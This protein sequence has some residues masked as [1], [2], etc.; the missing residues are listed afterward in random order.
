MQ[1]EL[2]YSRDNFCRTRDRE[3]AVALGRLPAGAGLISLWR[4]TIRQIEP[5]TTA[6]RS[7]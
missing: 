5:V 1:R 6:L 3:D 2:H 4:S 7:N